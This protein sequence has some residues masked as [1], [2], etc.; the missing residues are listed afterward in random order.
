MKAH[1]LVLLVLVSILISGCATKEKEIIKQDPYS[2][3]KIELQGAFIELPSKNIQKTCT[4]SLLE[5]NTIYQG[6]IIF[7][8]YQIDEYSKL[9]TDEKLKK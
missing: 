8:D 1:L 7:Y 9:T 3:Q 2:F 5:L 6:V 4:P